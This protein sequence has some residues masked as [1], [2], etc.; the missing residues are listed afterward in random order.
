MIVITK[1]NEN[2]EVKEEAVSK[3]YLD[4]RNGTKPNFAFV[5][6]ELYSV[7]KKNGIF[8]LNLNAKEE[9]NDANITERL[10][11]FEVSVMKELANFKD[12]LSKNMNE[13]FNKLNT[14]VENRLMMINEKVNER[15]DY[16]FEKTN[17]T[18]TN[19]IERLSKIDEAQ[20]KIDNLSSD[21][22]SL[23]SI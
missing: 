6:K 7:I 1:S 14:N 16:N 8:E 4:D 5:P 23:E 21:I 11:R 20:K 9:I 12:G 15:L 18:F 22:K 10:G 2:E 3:F 13:D 19:V 17:K